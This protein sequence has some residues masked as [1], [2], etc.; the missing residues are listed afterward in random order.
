MQAKPADRRVNQVSPAA[1][2]AARDKMISGRL[3][4]IHSSASLE[5]AEMRFR[6]FSS[7]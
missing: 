3:D 1:Y 4:A 2:E 6:Y 5:T 7:L